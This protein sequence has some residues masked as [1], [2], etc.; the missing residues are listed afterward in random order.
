MVTSTAAGGRLT[1]A[2]DVIAVKLLAVTSRDRAAEAAETA[3]ATE[4]ETMTDADG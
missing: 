1:H 3:W 4:C 2:T